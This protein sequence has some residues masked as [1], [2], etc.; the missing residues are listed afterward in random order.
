MPL[1]K[2][3]LSQNDEEHPAFLRPTPPLGVPQKRKFTRNYVKIR[4]FM[5]FWAILLSTC[6]QLVSTAPMPSPSNRWISG[7]A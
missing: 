1:T 7:L 2:L 5:S 6:L 3:A 4:L